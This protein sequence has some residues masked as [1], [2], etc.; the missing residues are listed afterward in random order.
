[1][2][3]GGKKEG[4]CIEIYLVGIGPILN[5]DDKEIIVQCTL[6]IASADVQF[7]E[8]ERDLLMC[9]DL[10]LQIIQ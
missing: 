9:L 1:M 5:S 10:F 8:E 2:H 7:D 6:G 4:K 3:R